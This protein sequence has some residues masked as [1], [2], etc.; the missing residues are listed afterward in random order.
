MRLLYWIFIACSAVLNAQVNLGDFMKNKALEAKDKAKDYAHDKLTDKLEK[1]RQQFD[2]SNFNYAICFTENSGAFES[3]EKG[4]AVSHVLLNADQAIQKESKSIEQRAYTNLR[5]GELMMAGNK[6]HV[7]EKSFLLAKLLY[8]SDGKGNTLNYA[9][10]LSNLGLLYQTMGRLTQAEIYNLKALQ[11]RQSLNN[12]QVIGVSEN[13]I[14]VV[15]KE[16]GQYY[17]AMTQFNRALSHTPNDKLSQALIKN[18]MA[19]LQ[20]DLNNAKSAEKYMQQALTDA[21]TALKEDAANFIKLQMNLAAVYKQLKKYTQAESL[22]IKAIAVKEKKLG[23]HPDLATLKKGL[24]QLYLEMGKLTEAGSLL[25]SALEI[26]K[27]KL[28]DQHPATLSVME[29]LGTYYRLTNQAV[30]AIELHAYVCEKRKILY[31]DNHPLYIQA[32]ESLAL[33]QFKGKQLPSS[34]QHYQTIIDHTQQFIRTTF[35]S[36]NEA[37]KSNY[38]SR[39]ATRLNQYYAVILS[40][41]INQPSLVS[42]AYNTLLQTRGFLMDGS[43]RLRHKIMSST[44]TVLIRVYKDWLST[45][46]QINHAYELSK[47]EIKQSQINLDS[48]SIRAG[49]LERNLSIKSMDFKSQQSTAP[50]RFESI[51]ASLTKGEACI[52]LLKVETSPTIKNQTLYYAFILSSQSLKLVPLGDANAIDKAILTFREKAI[53]AQAEQDAWKIVWKPLEPSL[54]SVQKLFICPDG[55]YHLLSF[56]A[57]KDLGG[58]YLADKYAWVTTS[59]S[60]D[61]VEI[62]QRERIKTKPKNAYLLSNPAF[63]GGGV[64][65]QLPGAEAEAMAIGKILLAGGIPVLKFNGERATEKAVKQIKSPGILHIATHGYFLE[66]ASKVESQKLLGVETSQAAENPLLRCG[67]LFAGCENVFDPDYHPNGKEENGVLTAFEAMRLNLDETY[68]VVL[69]ACET[70]LGKVRNGE[71]VYGLQRTLLVA[72]AKNILVSLWPVSD[73]ATQLLMTHFYTAYLKHGQVAMAYN[74]AMRLLRK[75]HTQPYYWGAFVL[76]SR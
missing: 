20:L 57:L 15:Y 8:E 26:N 34:I 24:A 23:V 14:G 6:F 32:L 56:P 10:T 5:N 58:K 68:L 45:M 51:Q 35:K 33:S 72:G 49:E 47:E 76:I 62:K 67:L 2:E 30:K 69:S 41:A 29:S 13:N 54:T 11:V 73:E 22:Y 4:N 17:E 3:Q 19:M 31:G 65:E 75:T 70:G 16:S 53:A 18:N 61:V 55:L 25:S 37:E 12:T 27:K 63:G 38:W 60:R 44:D 7:A 71:G 28:G 36:L 50:F 64:I 74:E 66:D 21:G 48:L 46:E 43:S 1:Q 9:Q 59:N 52:D 40:Q 39:T 42:S